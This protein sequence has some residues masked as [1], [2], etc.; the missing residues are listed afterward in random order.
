MKRRNN[1]KNQTI[2]YIGE[3]VGISHNLIKGHFD[4]KNT[5]MFCDKV[6]LFLWSILI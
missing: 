5:T 2:D 1:Y 3:I 6:L 4:S